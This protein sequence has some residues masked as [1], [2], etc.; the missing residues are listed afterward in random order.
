MACD[1]VCFVVGL[2]AFSAMLRERA[3]HIL[4]RFLR[5]I[6]HRKARPAPPDSPASHSAIDALPPVI[7][8]DDWRHVT[9][10]DRSAAWYFDRR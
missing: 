9:L 10:I 6:F 7:G 1:A 4:A 2:A 8:P 5:L 3:M